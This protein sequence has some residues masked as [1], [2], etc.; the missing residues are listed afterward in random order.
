MWSLALLGV[1]AFGIGALLGIETELK[2]AK[3]GNYYPAVETIRGAFNLAREALKNDGDWNDCSGADRNCSL[4]DSNGL[5]PLYSSSLGK[6]LENVSTPQGFKY[7]VKIKPVSSDVVYVVVHVEGKGIGLYQGAKFVRSGGRGK[8]PLVYAPT[9]TVTGGKACSWYW[10]GTQ[11]KGVTRPNFTVYLDDDFYWSP[12]IV[13]PDS[14]A[15]NNPKDVEFA[16]DFDTTVS[17]YREIDKV[18]TTGNLYL[19]NG[20]HL[21]LAYADGEVYIDEDSSADKIVENGSF[22]YPDFRDSIP[23]NSIDSSTLYGS[24]N[25]FCW[26][27][28]KVITGIH[29]YRN[30]VAINCNL[31]L[32]NARVYARTYYSIGG[33]LTLE[34]SRFY[35]AVRFTALK[36]VINQ[37]D[38]TLS[39]ENLYL[40]DTELRWRGNSDLKA[41]NAYLKDTE[42]SPES[43]FHLKAESLKFGGINDCRDPQYCL[44][45]AN[46]IFVF[47]NSRVIG[48]VL[49]RT[50][51]TVSYGAQV[52]GNTFAE[53]LEASGATFCNVVDSSGNQ[54]VADRE[55]FY[56]LIAPNGII[57]PGTAVSEVARVV[58]SNESDCLTQLG[59][60]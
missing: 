52:I 6:T 3:S 48:T 10:D 50:E 31:R 15:G 22:D 54:V 33:T 21:G 40:S 58:C 13:V 57:L 46:S 1:L 16:T 35:T 44:W 42:V 45:D 11:L 60:E 28:T 34:N 17:G 26:G 8:I 38:S 7:T 4:A 39:A 14:P 43:L 59:A 37:L 24:R 18:Y 56:H 27:Q 47:P 20:A 36:S 19:K 49:A 53:E 32:V 2:T 5:F 23:D 30:F 25:Y 41:V 55:D 51:M 12:E 9:S 29:Y